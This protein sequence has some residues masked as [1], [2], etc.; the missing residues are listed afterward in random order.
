M[1]NVLAIL[2]CGAGAAIYIDRRVER[3]RIE[4]EHKWETLPETLD[5]KYQRKEV[6]DARHASLHWHRRST[7]K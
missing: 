4:W 2:G 1:V 6:C 3:I 7:D 5:Q